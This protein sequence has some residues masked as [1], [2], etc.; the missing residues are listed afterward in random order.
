MSPTIQ[1]WIQIWR[2]TDDSADDS[3]GR[4]ALFPSQPR[5]QSQP[6]S[7]SH[8][9]EH[10]EQNQTDNEQYPRDMGSGSGNTG[11]AK[12]RRDQRNNQKC[13]SP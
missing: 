2:N 11:K 3:V 12:D 9:R 5:F 8:Y 13:H 4:I 1:I 10:D 6:R 7:S